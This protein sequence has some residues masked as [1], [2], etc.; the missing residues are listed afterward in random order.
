MDDLLPRM[1]S[2]PPHP[3]PPKPLSDE[4]YDEGIKAQIAFMQQKATTKHILDLTSGGEST[5]NVINPALNTVPYIFTLTAQLSEALTS[6]STKDTEWLWA[7][8]CNFMSS[9]DPRQIRYLG[10]QLE[11]LLHDGKTFARR[12]GQACP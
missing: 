2:F 4:K 11:K 7:K 9:F 10:I 12:L 6:N 8:I 3:P 1:L 5:L